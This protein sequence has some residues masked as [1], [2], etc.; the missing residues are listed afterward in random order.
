MFT[1]PDVF[2]KVAQV[3]NITTTI[4][5]PINPNINTPILVVVVMII[6]LSVISWVI[7][8]SGSGVTVLHVL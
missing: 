3:Y 7:V 2:L 5:N 6:V 4:V 1:Q 8:T